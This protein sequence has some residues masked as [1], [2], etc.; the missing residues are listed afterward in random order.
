MVLQRFAFRLSCHEQLIK[1]GE[2]QSRVSKARSAGDLALRDGVAVGVVL[3]G[4]AAN[5]NKAYPSYMYTT[6]RNILGGTLTACS[7][8]G[9]LIT[10]N[11]MCENPIQATTDMLRHM[12]AHSASRAFAAPT[13]PEPVAEVSYPSQ[14]PVLINYDQFS[15][16]K[17][18]ILK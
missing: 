18:L 9:Q 15:A 3:V 7:D 4:S 5:T 12:A 14:P 2:H 10:M 1:T 16:T 8:C 11:K 13:R 17:S 6:T